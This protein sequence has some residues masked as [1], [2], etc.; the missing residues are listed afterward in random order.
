MSWTPRSANVSS[1]GAV[2]PSGATSPAMLT[3]Q[4]ISGPRGRVSGGVQGAWYPAGSVRTRSPGRG[5]RRRGQRRTGNR[6]RPRPWHRFSRLCSGIYR[7][8]AHDRNAKRGQWRVLGDDDLD[9]LDGGGES[10]R[11]RAR[12]HGGGADA[13]NAN[14][15]SIRGRLTLNLEDIAAIGQANFESALRQNAGAVVSDALDSQ[16]ITGNGTAPNL[17]GLSISSPTRPTRP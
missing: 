6:G 2:F 12:Q 5:P 7:E 14:P 17:D 13:D 8:Q 10:K 15:R 11:H 16:I 4:Q 3:G 9:Q 1:S